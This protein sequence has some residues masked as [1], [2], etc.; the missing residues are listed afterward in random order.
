M[1]IQLSGKTCEENLE[2]EQKVPRPYRKD[3]VKEQ[4]LVCK[5]RYRQMQLP[6]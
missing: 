3:T 6:M 4:G 2:K 1:L 5:A